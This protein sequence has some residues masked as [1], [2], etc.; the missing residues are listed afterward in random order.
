MP[1]LSNDDRLQIVNGTEWRVWMVNPTMVL[2]S[3]DVAS[4]SVVSAGVTFFLRVILIVIFFIDESI[5]NLL[6]PVLSGLDGRGNRR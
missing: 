3:E 4:S 1:D 6:M 2:L 5:R